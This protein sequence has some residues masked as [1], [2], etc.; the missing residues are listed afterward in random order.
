V[1]P[2]ANIVFCADDEGVKETVSGL[3]S[4]IGMTPVDIGGLAR[5]VRARAAH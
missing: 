2:P 5:P 1:K 4:D 3:I